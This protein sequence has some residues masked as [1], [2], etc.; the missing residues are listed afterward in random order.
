VTSDMVSCM[1]NAVYVAITSKMKIR[2]RR[3]KALLMEDL[4]FIVYLLSTFKG[5][6]LSDDNISY[7]A[8]IYKKRE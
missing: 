5:H 7:V 4:S 1:N 3:D 2:I 6:M 8:I